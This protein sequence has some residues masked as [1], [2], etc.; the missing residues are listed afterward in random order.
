MA[1][2]LETV[3]NLVAADYRRK[4]FSEL[5]E[6]REHGPDCFEREHKGEK[7]SFEI[8][9]ESL[10]PDSVRVRVHGSPPGPLAWAR[11]FAVYFGMQPDGHVIEGE[12][13]WF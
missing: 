7:Y 6:L 11:G 1:S 13:T 3:V 9:V 2:K 12:A 4:Q 8:D 10:G 5:Q